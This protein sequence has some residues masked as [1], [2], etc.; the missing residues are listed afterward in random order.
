MEA[1]QKLSRHRKI[2]RWHNWQALTILWEMWKTGNV[3][4][5]AVRCNMLLCQLLCF[6]AHVNKLK[7]G[8]I[9]L[10]WFLTLCKKQRP[11]S[12]EALRKLRTWRQTQHL[13]SNPASVIKREGEEELLCISDKKKNLLFTTAEYESILS[14]AIKTDV[15]RRNR[16]RGWGSSWR[17]RGREIKELQIRE[18]W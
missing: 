11:K 7:C 16:G 18:D 8:L 14:K 4:L 2:K 10:Q 1:Y 3:C 13:I 12:A 17:D 6:P 5:L 15:R 9:N